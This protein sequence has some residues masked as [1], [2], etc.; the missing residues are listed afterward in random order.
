MTTRSTAS[1]DAEIIDLWLQSQAST[2]TQ[3]CY[4]RDVARLLAHAGKPLKRISLGDL[5]GFAQCLIETGLAPISRARTLAATKSL[6]GFC[7]RMRYIPSR[8]LSSGW[9]R[10][11]HHGQ[12]V[13]SR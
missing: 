5:H 8:F 12:G 1:G 7:Q 10:A 13:D 2:H 11:S 6:L 4:R 9:M 3:S